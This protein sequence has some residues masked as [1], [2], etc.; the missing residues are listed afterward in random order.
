MMDVSDGDMSEASSDERS[1]DELELDDPRLTGSDDDFSDLSSVESEKEDES[2]P[3]R[4]ILCT[5]APPSTNITIA[6]NGPNSTIQ[7]TIV[8]N[9]TSHSINPNSSTSVPESASQATS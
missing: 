5:R 6:A 1:E 7:P 9:P 8:A 3:D 2:F 4:S